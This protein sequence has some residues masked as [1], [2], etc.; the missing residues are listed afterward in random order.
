MTATILPAL[1]ERFFTQ[2]LI[3]QRCV[4]PH[5]VA[6]YRDTFRLLLK[7]AHSRLRKRPSDLELVDLDAPFIV[8]F[9]D[10][11]EAQRA[12]GANTRNLRLTAISSLLS[13]RGVRRTGL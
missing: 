1:V 4:S 10:D 3:Q 9:L 8:A 2:R 7:F 5:T 12:V 13:L 11:L 6:S